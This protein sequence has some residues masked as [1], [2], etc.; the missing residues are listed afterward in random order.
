M[1]FPRSTEEGICLLRSFVAHVT[2]NMS[3]SN[4]FMFTSLFVISH[5]FQSSDPEQNQSCLSG[6]KCMISRQCHSSTELLIYLVHHRQWSGDSIQGLTNTSPK[7][8][9][10]LLFMHGLSTFLIQVLLMHFSYSF[11]YRDTLIHIHC[12]SM[13]FS[14]PSLRQFLLWCS[15]YRS[16]II[17]YFS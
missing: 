9:P 14:N 10:A 8:N 17:E 15:M 1:C 7:Y 6:V 12:K 3:N 4:I 13:W 16:S 2:A 11:S 5:S